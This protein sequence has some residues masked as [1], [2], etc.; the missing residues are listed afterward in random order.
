MAQHG[1]VQGG[2]LDTLLVP[3]L[4]ALPGEYR[5]V[6]EYDVDFAG[7]W[8]DVFRRFVDSDADLLTS[9]VLFRREQP[10]WNHWHW[11]TAPPGI[12]RRLWVRSFNPLMRVGRRM[13]E[14]YCAAMADDAWQGHYEFTMATAAHAAGL[15]VEDLGGDTSFTPEGRCNQLYL[16]RSPAGRPKDLT[17][18]FRPVRTHYYEERP[19][20]FEQ[21]GLLYHPVKP[22]VL[23]WNRE[24]RNAPRPWPPARGGDADG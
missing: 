23:A 12:A 5:W 2:Y 13:L 8:E 17:F 15:V 18:G 16:G 22:G 4:R 9:S 19:E 20:T 7:R 1:G 24:T 10:R 6:C 11:A 21:E 14:V 3:L